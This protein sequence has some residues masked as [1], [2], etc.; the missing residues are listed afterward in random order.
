MCQVFGRFGPRTPENRAHLLPSLHPSNGETN[1]ARFLGSP[2]PAGRK[3]GTFV[4]CACFI[5]VGADVGVPPFRGAAA[6]KPCTFA[7]FLPA[8]QE[9]KDTKCARKP[10]TL[11]NPAA[12]KPGTFAPVLPAHQPRARKPGTFGKSGPDCRRQTLFVKL[13][14][15]H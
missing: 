8:H 10:G 5:R 14:N 1:C 7:P 13:R 15:F 6:R 12:R 11:T 2:G 9:R 4:K 3:P